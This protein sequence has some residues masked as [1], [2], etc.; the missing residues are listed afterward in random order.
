MGTIEELLAA[1]KARVEAMTPEE[2]E[3]MWEAQRQLF[4]RS[5]LPC[6]HGVR[7]WEYCPDCRS[8]ALLAR[9]KP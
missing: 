8:A 6:E 1:A 3:A 4:A 2:R 7:D 5:M 9:A